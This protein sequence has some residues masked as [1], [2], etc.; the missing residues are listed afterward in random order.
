MLPHESVEELSYVHHDS[1]EQDCSNELARILAVSSGVSGWKM[2]GAG[3][4]TIS[5]GNG[6]VLIAIRPRPLCFHGAGLIAARSSRIRSNVIGSF[7]IRD[8]P[9]AVRTDAAKTILFRALESFLLNHRVVV[10]PAIY[11]STAEVATVDA[12]LARMRTKVVTVPAPVG[13]FI[14][15]FKVVHRSPSLEDEQRASRELFQAT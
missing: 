14:V 5:I 6:V 4:R 12:R 9:S 1:N 15:N 11:R 2:L 13:Y 7:D 8:S 3:S 10:R